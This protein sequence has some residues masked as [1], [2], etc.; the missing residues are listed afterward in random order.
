MYIRT[1]FTFRYADCRDIFHALRGHVLRRERQ[2]SVG[3]HFLSRSDFL[4]AFVE[5]RRRWG[6]GG[7]GDGRRGAR[8]VSIFE[9]SFN[10]S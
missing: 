4:T 9:K 7:A 8:G 2:N 3:T 10:K 1:R 5:T 6:P